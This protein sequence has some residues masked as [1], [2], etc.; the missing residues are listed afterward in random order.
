MNL[1]EVESM[2]L[3]LRKI[4]FASCEEYIEDLI[5]NYNYSKTDISWLRI[6][7]AS[8]HTSSR[9]YKKAYEII[10]GIL[11]EAMDDLATIE[12]N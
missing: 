9:K 1:R 10:A 11:D 8:L 7:L 3:E 4:D 6:Q 2:I 12:S 5:Q